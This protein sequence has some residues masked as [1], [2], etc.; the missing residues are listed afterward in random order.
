MGH[1]RGVRAV[2]IRAK[3]ARWAWPL[4]SGQ[5][6]GKRTGLTSGVDW[7]KRSKRERAR[8]SADRAGLPSRE[9]R[10]R[11]GARLGRLV[12]TERGPGWKGCGLIFLFL[13]FPPLDS[14]LNM[15]LIQTY[16]SNKDNSW[17]STLCNISYF[18][19]TCLGASRMKGIEGARI[20]H[21]LKFNSGG[22]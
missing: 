8:E 4:R 10:G 11:R 22:F 15:S 14:N 21:Y 9:R 18:L 17:G 19:R 6:Q 1:G 16:A 7:S 3:R 5:L 13:L 12:V 20:P 2:V